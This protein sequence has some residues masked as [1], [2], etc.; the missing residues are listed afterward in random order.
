MEPVFSEPTEQT[1]PVLISQVELKNQQKANLCIAKNLS[2]S[3]PETRKQLAKGMAKVN[4]DSQPKKIVEQMANGSY[5]LYY[6]EQE[7]KMIGYATI[8]PEK[9]TLTK[10][11]YLNKI[12][13]REDKTQNGVATKIIEQVMNDFDEI[14]LIDTIDEGQESKA[15]MVNTY[16]RLGFV[17]EDGVGYVWKKPV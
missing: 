8:F 2:M 3:T 12:Y 7:G 9:D 16:S 6:I 17:T 15:G 13:T 10:R 14:S 5:D 11:C 4:P 1:S